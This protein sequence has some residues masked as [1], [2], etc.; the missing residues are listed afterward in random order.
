MILQHEQGLIRNKHNSS[1]LDPYMVKGVIDT[2]MA[3]GLGVAL[4]GVGTWYNLNNRSAYAQATHRWG[5]SVL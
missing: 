5:P 3:I 4:N 2:R 1:L